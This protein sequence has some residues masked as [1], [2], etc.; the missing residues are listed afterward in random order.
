MKSKLIYLAVTAVLL[1]AELISIG[2][3]KADKSNNTIV[4]AEVKRAGYETTPGYV[5][6]EASPNKRWDDANNGFGGVLII[7]GLIAALGP[8][9]AAFAFDGSNSKSG[10]PLTMWLTGAISLLLVFM[11]YAA[12]SGSSSYETNICIDKYE[13]NKSNL[14]A[15]FPGVD[16]EL[17]CK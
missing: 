4:Y 17:N 1:A 2:I 11:P 9:I 5:Y 10:G 12:K 13:A 14:D 16:E 8:A 7:I 3:I 15:L 6:V